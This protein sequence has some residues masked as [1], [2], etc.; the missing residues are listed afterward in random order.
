MKHFTFCCILLMLAVGVQAQGNQRLGS[1]RKSVVTSFPPTYYDIHQYRADYAYDPDLSAP[2]IPVLS[3]DIVLHRVVYDWQ[4]DNPTPWATYYE[5]DYNPQRLALGDTVRII[6]T[7]DRGPAFY[8][9][10]IIEDYSLDGRLLRYVR[11][12]NLNNE[13]NYRV[14]TLVYDPEGHLLSRTDSTFT[15]GE[16]LHERTTHT[17]DA[18]QQPVYTEILRAGPTPGW[19]PYKSYTYAYHDA[20]YPAGLS[21]RPLPPSLELDLPPALTTPCKIDSVNIHYHEDGAWQLRRTLICDAGDYQFGQ[22]VTYYGGYFFGEDF[23]CGVGW[24]AA[25]LVTSFNLRDVPNCPEGYTDYLFTWQEHSPASDE[26]VPT[27]ATRARLYPNPFTDR[28]RIVPT[29]L[30]SPTIV[31][32]YNIRGQRL[33]S[34]NVFPDKEIELDLD[35]SRLG[36]LPPGVYLWRLETDGGVSWLRSLKSK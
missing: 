35:R 27:P 25:G 2:L 28:V 23:Y 5:T 7:V 32:L 6:Y 3:G 34:W 4:P 18:N 24:N 9:Q 33:Y 22:Y 10:R 15:N 36:D 1:M 26:T 19:E 20:N 31:S 11:Y 14:R 8:P 17:L 13:Q 16:A 12:P 21:I 29:G 30:M